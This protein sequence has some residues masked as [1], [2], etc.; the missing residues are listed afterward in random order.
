MKSRF[1][2]SLILLDFCSCRWLREE[3]AEVYSYNY[4]IWDQVWSN[5]DSELLAV[6]T[7]LEE[8]FCNAGTWVRVNFFI[9]IL[10]PPPLVS[11]PVVSFPSVVSCS[12]PQK[13]N[14][15]KTAGKRL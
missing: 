8:I 2:A 10:S 13:F 14:K 9:E 12:E 6:R 4:T 11:P 5:R 3:V 15:L 7:N 1:L